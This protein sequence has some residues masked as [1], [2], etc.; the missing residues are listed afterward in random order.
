MHVLFAKQ[1]RLP[2]RQ[3]ESH[4]PPR[5]STLH[6]A[7]HL[8][9]RTR[10]GRRQRPHRYLRV[11]W[12][13]VCPGR[14]GRSE[15]DLRPPTPRASF[16]SRPTIRT[17]K[18]MSKPASNSTPWDV[19]PRPTR[20]P[21]PST[22]AART[23]RQK[24]RRWTMRTAAPSPFAGSLTATPADLRSVNRRTDDARGSG[25]PVRRPR[26][27]SRRRQHPAALVEDG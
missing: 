14:C 7:P 3:S 12:A 6:H 22:H 27:G 24:M 18:T 16:T 13:S 2:A 25:Q 19:R 20:E 11:L 23:H 10:T 8:P 1:S 4:H 9:R 5:R 21:T 15:G 26:H 17:P